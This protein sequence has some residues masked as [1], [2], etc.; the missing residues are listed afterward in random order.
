MSSLTMVSFS[1]P[2]PYMNLLNNFFYHVIKLNGL[3]FCILE[4]RKLALRYTSQGSTIL[5]CF[6]SLLISK[7]LYKR[8]KKQKYVFSTCWQTKVCSLKKAI[9]L[10]PLLLCLFTHL[11]LPF[12]WQ[13]FVNLS[14]TLNGMWSSV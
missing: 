7:L 3:L 1:L 13:S 10:L 2:R 11:N 4:S 14:E 6:T 8:E 12:W 9:S 5:V